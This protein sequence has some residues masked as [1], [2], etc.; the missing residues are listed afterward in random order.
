ML[1]YEADI[2][3]TSAQQ[4]LKKHGF[5]ATKPTWKPGLSEKAREK[6][7]AFALQFESW[8]IEKWKD[9]VWT[10]E[11]SVVLGHHQGAVRVK[12]RVFEVNDPTVICHKWKGFSDF[13]FWGCFS[14]EECG[15]CHIWFTETAQEKKAAEK[16]LEEM[17]KEIEPKAR[18]DWEMDQVT[19]GVECLLCDGR[20]GRKPTFHFSAKTGKLVWN[21]K[22]GVDWYRYQKVSSGSFYK[23]YL[24]ITWVF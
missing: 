1:A 7:L 2:S 16:E 6:C 8:G 9:V 3:A 5:R 11:T 14:Y 20:R 17:N 19:G 13:M 22:G 24:L 4:I 10:D 18:Y 21:G 15:P 12:R 23:I